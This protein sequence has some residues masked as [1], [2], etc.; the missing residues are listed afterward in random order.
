VDGREAPLLRA[1]HTF[2]AIPVPAGQHEVVM[3]YSRETVAIW[4]WVSGSL[5]LVLM[6]TAFGFGL[7]QR[8][9]R[10]RAEATVP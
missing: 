7:W 8:T 3:R 5:L 1:N 6:A 10:L 9:R 4:A 2:R